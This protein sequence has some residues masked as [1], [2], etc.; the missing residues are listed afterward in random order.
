MAVMV[1]GCGKLPE[2]VAV[3]AEGIW[4][5]QTCSGPRERSKEKLVV[6]GVV[7]VVVCCYFFMRT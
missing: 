4:M 3:E 7:L 2:L 5:E 1:A 6:G